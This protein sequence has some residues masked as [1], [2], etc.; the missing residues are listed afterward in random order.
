MIFIISFFLL[1]LGFILFI[2]LL[3][4]WLGYLFKIFLVFLRKAFGAAFVALHRFWKVVFPFTFVLKYFVIS[5]LIFSLTHW[6]F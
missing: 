3:D 2:I 5:S 4:D 6:F 1:T